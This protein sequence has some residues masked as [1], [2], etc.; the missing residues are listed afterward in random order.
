MFF[1]GDLYNWANRYKANFESKKMSGL[2]YG[3][4]STIYVGF[5]NKLKKLAYTKVGS[6]KMEG[7]YSTAP[8]PFDKRFDGEYIALSKGTIWA[9]NTFDCMWVHCTGNVTSDFGNKKLRFKIDLGGEG[10]VCDKNGRPTQGI[11]NFVS[12]YDYS[13]GK[14]GKLIVLSEGLVEGGVID[15]WIDAAANDLFGKFQQNAVIKCADIVCE[16]ENIRNLAYDVEVLLSACDYADKTQASK[17]YSELKKLYKKCSNKVTEKVASECR[18]ILKP[19]FDCFK[20]DKNFEYTAIGHAHLDLAWLWP[21]RET[22]RKG[23][24]TFATQI[25]N[26]ERYPNYY[27]GASQAQLF[28]WIKQLDIDLYNKIC[29]KVKSHRLEVQGATWVEMDSNLIGMESL[30][31]QFY[32]G[33]KYFLQEFGCDMKI[34][35]LPDSFGYSACIPQIMNLADCPYFL[36]QKLSWNTVTKFHYHTFNWVGLDG[37]EVFAHMLPNNSYNSPNRADNLVFGAKNYQEREICNKALTL[38]GIGDGGAGPGFEHIERAKRLEN[39]SPV[40]NVKMGM[41]VDFF[42]DMVRDREKFKKYQGELYLEKHQGTYTTQALT[43]YYNRK[44]E[45]ALRNYELLA[46]LTGESNLPIDFVSFEKLWKEILLYQFHDILPGSSI[47]RVYDEC[48]VRYKYILDSLND[49]IN[50]M[51]SMIGSGKMLFNPNSFDTDYYYKENNAWYKITLPKLS[52]VSCEKAQVVSGLVTYSENH[53][54]NE[55]VKIT[56]YKGEII[57]YFDKKINKSFV[58]EKG[59]FL[60]YNVYKDYGDC[61]DMRKNYANSK[62][63]LKLESFKIVS[64]GV[65]AVAESV[66]VLNGLK[67]VQNVSLTGNE[68]FVR[69]NIQIENNRDKSML[70]VKFESNVYS[71]KCTFNTQNG[72]IYRATTENNKTEIAQYEVCGQKFVDLS[73]GN[74]GIAIINDCKYGFRCKGSTIDMNLLRSPHNPAH[75]VDKGEFVVHLAIYTHKGEVNNSVYERAYIINNP[76]YEY[77]GNGN[78][79]LNE[80]SIDN[81]NIVVE[82]VKKAD[83]GGII[84][85]VYNCYNNNEKFTMQAKQ[86]AN[87]EIVNILENK[88]ADFCGVINIKPFEIINIRFYN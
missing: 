24:R 64:D 26:M 37:S 1:N 15:F 58:L 9:K 59:R 11:T 80:I 29:D 53:I 63:S 61:W 10:L 31:R 39:L 48:L 36:T 43:K 69:I 14:P 8:L 82:S 25:M 17:I 55:N 76:V 71:D 54:E 28:D 7:Y 84:V 66:F 12:E 45:F 74:S 27:F 72:H 23:L 68:D 62:K 60:K 67:V 21:I 65:K 86:Y 34:L 16:N 46:C 88:I 78:C 52:S 5:A 6:L 57:G 32:Y 4:K 73:D 42:D 3:N 79:K 40:P 22:K 49:G 18:D 85:R 47:D 83:N 87:A 13:L 44:C 33:K 38:F 77:V 81:K 19:L 51:L 2:Y 35:W 70:R 50:S 75:N 41:S 56:F 20:K 30:I